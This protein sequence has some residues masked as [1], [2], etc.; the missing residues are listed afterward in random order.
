MIDATKR[1]AT[2]DRVTYPRLTPR[3]HRIITAIAADAAQSEPVRRDAAGLL[4][5]HD[6]IC[7]T[8]VTDAQMA[9]AAQ[10]ILRSAAKRDSAESGA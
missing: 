5:R 10:H 8:G 2:D 3:L 7:V 1:H 6:T 4:L 9:R